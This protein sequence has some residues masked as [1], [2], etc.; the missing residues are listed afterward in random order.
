MLLQRCWNLLNEPLDHVTGILIRFLDSWSLVE[1]DGAC[2]E[3]LG[4]FF[5]SQI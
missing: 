1:Q 4:R 5:R 3:A 2:P